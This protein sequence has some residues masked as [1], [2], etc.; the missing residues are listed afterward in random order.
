MKLQHH[1]EI[2]A[3]LAMVW[4]LTSRIDEL[5]PCLPGG[6]AVKVDDRNF[7]TTMKLRLGPLDLLF[8]GKLT[9]QERDA[10]RSVM[11]I[12]AKA[13][14]SRGQGSANATTT[15]L[16][17]SVG[18][19]TR[20]AI[21]TDLVISGR[22]AQMGRGIVS[23]V[24]DDLLRKFVAN[25]EK[26]IEAKGG[27]PRT[28]VS[29]EPQQQ[30]GARAPENARTDSLNVFALMARIAWRRILRLLGRRGDRP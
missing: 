18:N 26:Y 21:D 6:S 29:S 30:Q 20:A 28:A 13:N 2:N 27:G 1:C 14:E 24:S 23:E 22:V 25:L 15:I 3:P 17:T 10:A 5:A 12:S 19:L 9:V 11:V 4:E 16:L 7:D 8:R